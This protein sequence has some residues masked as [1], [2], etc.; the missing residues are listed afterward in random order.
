MTKY[1]KYINNCF[2]NYYDSKIGII[3]TGYDADVFI[4]MYRNDY[5]ISKV[6]SMDETKVGTIFNNYAVESFE[7]IK[8][9]DGKIIICN[10]QNEECLNNLL[11]IKKRDIGLFFESYCYKYKPKNKIKRKNNKY[12]IGYVAGVFDLFHIGHLNLLK[13]AYNLCDYL[14]VGV[15]SDKSAIEN[16]HKSL[17]IPFIERAEIVRSCK[18]VDE[19]VEIPF[20]YP[21]SYQAFKKYHFDVQ[22]SGSDY[23]HN[24]QWLRV[25]EFLKQ[26][27]SDMLFVPYTET[28]S[29]TKIKNKIK[30]DN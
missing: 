4:N 22:I 20:E 1:D 7:K 11:S 19:V 17:V 23:E 16:N 28:N 21:S 24:E 29:T 8:Q 6:F 9:F 3:G 26:N 14:I 30:H 2:S 27:G 18:Y 10:E 12:H 15:V 13:K 5:Q 25:K